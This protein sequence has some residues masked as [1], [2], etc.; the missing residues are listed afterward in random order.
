MTSTTNTAKKNVPAC[1]V[2]FI[3]ERRL[4]STVMAAMGRPENKNTETQWHKCGVG[5][6]TK[7]DNLTI[8]IGEKCSPAQKRA[9]ISFTDALDKVRSNPDAS[10][11]PVANVY[12][13]D[14][15]D[16]YDFDKNDGVAFLNN[17]ESLNLIV[18]DRADPEQLRY[19][20]RMIARR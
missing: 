19:V 1:E 2:F 11:I 14:S 8:L 15:D 13:A 17:D 5:F 7:S 20:V 12:L 18:G 3:E 6:L 10:R 9:L 16:K 4:D